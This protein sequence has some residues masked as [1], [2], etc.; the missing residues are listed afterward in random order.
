MARPRTPTSVLEARGAFKHDPQRRR[1]SEPVVTEPIGTPPHH[2]TAAQLLA[3]DEIVGYAPDGV[4]TSADRLSVEV[5]SVLL[6]EFRADPAEMSAPR[7]LRLTGLLGHFG[8]NP[9][10]RSKLSIK[11][12]EQS[13][14]TFGD[15][16][17]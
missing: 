9:A 13:K 14:N 6:A 17:Q 15:L 2:L 16:M 7:L 8:M 12:P 3:W 4:L 11:Q 5:A 10:D 1:P